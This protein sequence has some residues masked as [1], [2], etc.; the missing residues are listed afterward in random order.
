MGWQRVAAL[1]TR[2]SQQELAETPR[3]AGGCGGG[4][5]DCVAWVL[6]GA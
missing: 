6:S 3:A 4:G 5:A 2:P 1:E